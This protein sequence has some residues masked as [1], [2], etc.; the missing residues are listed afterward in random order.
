MHRISSK[1]SCNYLKKHTQS[2]GKVINQHSSHHPHPNSQFSFILFLHQISMTG[3][4]EPGITCEHFLSSENRRNQTCFEV[5]ICLVSLLHGIG[6]LQGSSNLN[7][8]RR[9]Y[10]TTPTH[11]SVFADTKLQPQQLT[12]V[13]TWIAHSLY[14][15][16]MSLEILSRF[17]IIDDG[18]TRIVR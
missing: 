9:F 16:N 18:K 10:A 1:S 17:L 15:T 13:K 3:F 11:T 4:S 8:W 14:S 5:S 12:Q 2:K 6:Y 7:R